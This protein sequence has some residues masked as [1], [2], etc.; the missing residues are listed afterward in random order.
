MNRVISLVALRG[1]AVALVVTLVRPASW[2]ASEWPERQ[3]EAVRRRRA[4]RRAPLG[5]GR[6]GRLAPLADPR[7]PGPPRVRRPLR[8]LRRRHSTT[9][10]R[11]GSARR[12]G[13]RSWTATTSS[14]STTARTS[15]SDLEARAVVPRPDDRRPRDNPR[16]EG[17]GSRR[18][19]P[20]SPVSRSGPSRADEAERAARRLR[21]LR[22]GDRGAVRRARSPRDGRPVGGGGSVGGEARRA[23]SGG[24]PRT[25][26]RARGGRRP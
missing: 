19:H 4:T 15:R 11:T 20:G 8:A 23:P 13:S 7:P 1:L 3:V 2:F 18:R 25:G 6:D 12:A 21:D 9:S 26:S 24:S 17:Y 10:S 14:S 16:I 5:D 22:P